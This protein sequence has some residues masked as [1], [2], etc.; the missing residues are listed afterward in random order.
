[1]Y[2]LTDDDG[3]F[4]K[5]EERLLRAWLNQLVGPKLGCHLQTLF[6][7]VMLTVGRWIVSFKIVEAF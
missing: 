2:Q 3:Q 4:D 7:P 6:D 5:K 1:M